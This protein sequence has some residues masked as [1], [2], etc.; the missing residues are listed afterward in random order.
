[1]FERGST[2]WDVA[3]IRCTVAGVLLLHYLIMGEVRRRTV[4]AGREDCYRRRLRSTD[5]VAGERRIAVRAPAA[6][7]G[8][9]FPRDA[10]DG[11][12]SSH[13]L[14]EKHRSQFRRIGLVSIVFGVVDIVWA[15]R[16]RD[17]GSPPPL[18]TYLRR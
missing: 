9:C 8:A 11:C 15:R 12:E 16:D 13:D 2:P 17:S 10:S 5:G 4:S 1:M 14:S 18:V 3:E 7:G 6:R